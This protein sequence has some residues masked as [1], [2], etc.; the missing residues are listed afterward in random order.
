MDDNPARPRSFMRH[1][2]NWVSWSGM[3]LATAALFAFFLLFAIDL[4]AGHRNPYVGILAYVVA[5]GFF[6]LGLGLVAT[7]AVLHW[8]AERR[9]VRVEAPLVLKI[10]LS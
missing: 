5:P 7:G 1:L 9:A 6:L 4:F 10:D 3:V 8:R 2:R